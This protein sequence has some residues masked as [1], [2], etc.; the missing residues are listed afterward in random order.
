MNLEY[1]RMWES[2]NKEKR[3]E[4]NR[5]YKEKSISW[6]REYKSQNPC[7]ICGESEPSCIDFHHVDPKTKEHDITKLAYTMCTKKL[8][9]ELAK[10]IPLCA[11][12][13]RKVHAGL[14]SV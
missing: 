4:Y 11:N 12:C 1:R 10:C 3:R 2:S 8:R 6:F 14:L 7:R 9:I 5:R 13:H